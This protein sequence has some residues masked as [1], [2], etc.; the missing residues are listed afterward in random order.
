M[1][2]NWAKAHGYFSFIQQKPFILNDTLRYNLTLGRKV[3]D[4]R[5]QQAID[6]AGLHDLVAEKGL[7]VVLDPNGANLS[8]GQNQR[9]EIARALLAERPILIADEATS[10]L[11]NALSKRIHQTILKDFKGTVIEVAHKVSDEERQWFTQVVK[12]G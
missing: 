3:S 4:S 11:D 7:D 5:L 8:G 12:L 1:S 2:G 10:A 6:Q 9:V